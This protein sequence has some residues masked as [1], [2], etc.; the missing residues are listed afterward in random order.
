[1]S[2]E[3]LRY[4]T[5]IWA[6][7]LLG[8][9]AWLVIIFIM[10]FFVPKAMLQS[11][12]KE[13]YFSPAEIEFF[14]GFPFAYMRTVMFMRLAGWPS[15]GKKRGL[16]EAHKLAP[17]WFRVTSKI[18]IIFLMVVFALFLILGAFLLSAFCIL[19]HC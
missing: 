16:M 1:M 11:Y 5:Y 15:S 2:I 3:L 13:P 12:F 6:I 7:L 18:M 9:I 10:H 4:P 14:T 17:E 19:G 8:L